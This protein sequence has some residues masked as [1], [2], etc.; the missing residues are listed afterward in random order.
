[1]GRVRRLTLPSLSL[2]DLLHRTRTA[3]AGYATMSRVWT[4]PFIRP[5]TDR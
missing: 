3:A 4:N 2:L 5:P 1:M